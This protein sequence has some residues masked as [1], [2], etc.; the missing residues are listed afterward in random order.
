MT[1]SDSDAAR[2]GA[3]KRDGGSCRAFPVGGVWGTRCRMHGGLSPW[4]LVRVQD[5]WNAAYAA[6]LGNRLGVGRW[7]VAAIPDRGWERDADRMLALFR[8]HAARIDR[9]RRK[10]VDKA[11][12]ERA[13]RRGAGLD[14]DPIPG[15]GYAVPEGPGFGWPV[16]GRERPQTV[17][18][19][20]FWVPDAQLRT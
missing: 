6:H 5:R 11:A 1:P 17:G 20:G 13:F 8:R 7:P 9:H 10:H 2:C 12:I 4:H 14:E 18:E 15:I 3:R 16:P 19:A